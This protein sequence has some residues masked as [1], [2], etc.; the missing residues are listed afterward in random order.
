MSKSLLILA[1]LAGTWASAQNFHVDNRPSQPAT[2]NLGPIQ[3]VLDDGSAETSIGDDKPF[4][5][6]NRF[7]PNAADYPF[8]LDQVEI[9]WS[10]TYFTV[11]DQ[12][13]LYIYQDADSNP[14]NGMDLLASYTVTINAVD[15][16]DV[17]NLPD[18]PILTGPSGDL[19][20][21]CVNR[22]A[23]TGATDFPASIDTSSSQE[24][25]WAGSYSGVITDPPEIPADAGFD[26]IDNF[27]F[28]GNWLIRASGTTVSTVPTLGQ[29]GLGSMLVL[30]MAAGIYVGRKS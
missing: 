12:F 22:F 24:R 3:F 25:S 9:F 28:A 15:A 19:A 18:G 23:A 7:T 21:G 5:W 30:L 13:S 16:Y 1:L 29:W 4:F 27:G 14:V 20:V 2:S 10:S 26:T 8:R 11:G 17:Y 6:F